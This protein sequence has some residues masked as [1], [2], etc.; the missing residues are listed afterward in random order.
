ME[1]RCS[2]SPITNRPRAHWTRAPILHTLAVPISSHHPTL[3]TDP[4]TLS[5]RRGKGHGGRHGGKCG[6]LR[7]VKGWVQTYMEKRMLDGH[8][9]ARENE[10]I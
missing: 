8:E 6:R 9:V 10:E 4:L 5:I 2:D 3:S 1:K 7:G